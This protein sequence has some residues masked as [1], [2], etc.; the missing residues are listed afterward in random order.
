MRMK[1]GEEVDR[2]RFEVERGKVREFARAIQDPNPRWTDEEVARG[3][4]LAGLPAPL[5]FVVVAGHHRD[6]R[7]AMEK[8]GVDIA[9]IVVGEVGWQYHRPLLVGDVLD[10]RRLVTG[11]R[12]REGKDGTMTMIDMETVWRDAAGEP[13][14]TQTETLIERAAR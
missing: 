2:V 5:T 10:G 6:Q 7:G 12:T 8:L 3:E 1:V 14:V 11:V 4:G 9:R 13:V